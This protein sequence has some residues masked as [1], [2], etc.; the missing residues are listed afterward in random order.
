M[1]EK[2]DNTC[3][4]NHNR[5]T[6][7]KLGFGVF[8]EAMLFLLLATGCISSA[9]GVEAMTVVGVTTLGAIGLEDASKRF[10]PFNL[11]KN[12]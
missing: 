4:F 9:E 2:R 11:K 10:D 3:H 6:S 12:K 8:L 1:P 7:R 5:L